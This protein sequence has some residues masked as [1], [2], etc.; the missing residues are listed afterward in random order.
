L[1]AQTQ[2]AMFCFNW[3]F[4]SIHFRECT[5]RSQVLLTPLLTIKTSVGMCSPSP[6]YKNL[7]VCQIRT[8]FRRDANVVLIFLAHSAKLFCSSKQN[9]FK[10]HFI[11][12]MI[13]YRCQVKFLNNFLV[14][15]FYSV[16]LWSLLWQLSEAAYDQI[17]GVKTPCAYTLKNIW[18]AVDRKMSV[19]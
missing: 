18:L 14:D 10:S 19:Q 4:F 8:S 12:S 1:D 2:L 16:F 3:P 17:A 6:N 15:I 5:L 9:M 7:T 13:F 11:Q